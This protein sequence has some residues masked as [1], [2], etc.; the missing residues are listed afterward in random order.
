MSKNRE[1][2]YADIVNL[3]KNVRCSDYDGKPIK[4]KLP[5]ELKEYFKTENQWLD[6]GMSIKE[7]AIYVDMHPNSMNK[8]LCKY[9]YHTD[10]EPISADVEVCA[11]CSLRQLEEGRCPV[12]GGFVSP[13]HRCSEWAP[14]KNNN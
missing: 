7:N 12:A 6:I 10:V 1:K 11:T 13:K 14:V 5:N 8:K 4:N 3:L 9:Y 2:Y